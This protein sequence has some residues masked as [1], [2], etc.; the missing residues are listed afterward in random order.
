MIKKTK[1][2]H[3]IVTWNNEEIIE[4][5]IDS[6]MVYCDKYENEI[7]VVD[8]DSKD[9]TCEVI[10]YK[11]GE[12]VNLIETGYNN[13]FSKA[14]NIGLQYASGEYIFFVNPDVI[15]IEDIITPMIKVLNDKEEVGVVSP[16]LLYKDM[17]YQVSTCNF[18]SASKVVWDDMHFYKFLSEEKK[19]KYA[20]AQY[21]KTN[22]RYVDWSYGA[23]HFCKKTDMDKVGAYPEGY[24]MYGE[25]TEFCMMF[26][27]KINKKTYYLGDAKLIHLGGYSEKQVLNS[28]KIVYGTRAA[29]YFVNKYY[30]KN[31][32]LRYRVVLFLVSYIKYLIFSVKCLVNSETKNLNGKN[33][34]KASWQTV[35]KYNGEQ[36]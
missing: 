31:R 19:A 16:C 7:I 29:M 20:Q 8:N 11:Y 36:N 30:G 14:N 18:P 1:I 35:C 6:L 2:S 9:R 15:F 12:K 34:W 3:I 33:K 23:A 27:D 22:N 28:K 13:G 32:L 26:L 10:K 4:E 5:C 17:S 25:D 21:K 24:F